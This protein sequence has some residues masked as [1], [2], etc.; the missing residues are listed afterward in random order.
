[1]DCPSR[2]GESMA[3]TSHSTGR[4][5]FVGQVALPVCD[6][7]KGSVVLTAAQGSVSLA[8]PNHQCLDGLL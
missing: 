7:M 8:T 3:F 6:T 5:L 4:A 1:M 2:D